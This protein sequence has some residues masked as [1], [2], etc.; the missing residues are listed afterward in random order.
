MKVKL[1]IF[2]FLL[3][4][5]RL[6]FGQEDRDENTLQWDYPIKPGT[7]EWATLRTWDEKYDVCQI[8]ADILNKMSTKELARICVNYPLFLTYPPRFDERQG[9][10]FLIKRFNGLWELSQRKDGVQEL[11]KA[12]AN[13]PVLTKF[14]KNNISEDYPVIK[15]PFLELVLAD[16][17]F[18]SRLNTEELNEF[19]KN[20]LN[21][22]ADKI[23]NSTIY[24][25]SNINRTMLLAVIIIDRQ[26]KMEKTTEQ[27]EMIQNFIENYMYTES[28]LVTKISKIIAEL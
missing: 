26:S 27:Q 5:I 20:V 15:L 2:V 11:I 10:N 12:Y 1:L 18:I 24:S 21:K 22:Y 16:S 14:D 6:S 8:P 4:N 19:K 28:D 17:L 3:I 23:Q 7:K 25:S 9:V 13:Y